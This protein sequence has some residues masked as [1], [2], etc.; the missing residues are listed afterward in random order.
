[1]GFFNSPEEQERKARLKALE[2][3]RVAFAQ[4][5][6]REGFAP[7]KMLFAQTMNGGFVSLCRANGKYC[8]IISPGFGTDEAFVKEEYD[9]LDYSIQ[10]VFVKAEGMGG[11]FGFGKKAEQGV[12]F[13][14]A[15]ADGGEARMPF[16]A[17]RNG[18][19][20]AKLAKNPLLK[21]QR[22]RGDSN[23][24]WDFKP[25]DHSTVQRAIEVAKGYFPPI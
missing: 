15:R 1:M 18:W 6:A 8:L 11:I 2:D 22:R 24:V 13:V 20:E 5:L 7:E 19:M 23:L 25:L 10:D 16:I 9:R 4:Q 21:T 12:E 14:I 17:G 3:K